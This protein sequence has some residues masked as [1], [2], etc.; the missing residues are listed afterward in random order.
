VRGLFP[1]ISV[2]RHQLPVYSPISL[3]ALLGALSDAAAPAELRTALEGALASRFHAEAVRLYGSGTQALQRAIELGLASAGSDR[4]VALPAYACYDVASAAIGAGAP[5]VLYDIDPTTLSPDIR[6]LAAACAAGASVVVVAHLYGIPVDWDAVAATVA[7]HGGTLIEDAAQGHGAFLRERPLGSL[8]PM[9][10]LSFGRGKGW[11]GGAGGALLY[12]HESDAE[13]TRASAAAAGSA[14]RAYVATA[15]QWLVGRPG[16]YAI[17]RRLP[18]LALGETRYHAPLP[19]AG[20]SALAAGL[21]LRLEHCSD[22]Q[23]ALRRAAGAA[24]ASDIADMGP[25]SIPRPPAGARPGYLRFPLRLPTGVESLAGEAVHLGVA[26]SYP[27]PLSR[28]PQLA[29]CRRS[30]GSDQFPGA[31]ELARTL[32]TLPT[33]SLM[34]ARERQGILRMLGRAL[35]APASAAAGTAG[36]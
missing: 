31:E 1:V 24:W 4:L 16:L 13:P 12:A 23:A 34:L 11:T 22:A 18:G 3:S 33:H 14:M 8:G 9:S 25:V 36:A 26:P 27:A 30:V 21:V 10:I 2:V 35:A 15:V 29:S 32:V 17:P 28:L 5:V 20:M 6:S 19:V 7:A